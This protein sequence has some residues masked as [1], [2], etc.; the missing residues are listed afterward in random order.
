MLPQIR[1]SVCNWAA[2]SYLREGFKASFGDHPRGPA[3]R[4]AWQA[5]AP[6]LTKAIRDGNVGA[7]KSALNAAIPDATLRVPPTYTEY[8]DIVFPAGE[9]NLLV[10]PTVRALAQ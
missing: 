5:A 2:D 9:M 1:I 3:L 6:L 7:M 4:A 8:W 10:S